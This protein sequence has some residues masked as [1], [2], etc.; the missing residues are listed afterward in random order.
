MVYQG[1]GGGPRTEPR[2]GRWGEEKRMRAEQEQQGSPPVSP[3]AEAW[4][5]GG[6]SWPRALQYPC[7]LRAELNP[8]ARHPELL[9][10]SD[11]KSLCFYV[12]IRTGFFLVM[13]ALQ[14]STSSN[15][16]PC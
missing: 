13:S 3:W 6:G 11:K 16:M 2:E 4:G 1:K 8:V 9:L 15:G 10:C 7:V 14:L 5:G 12:R